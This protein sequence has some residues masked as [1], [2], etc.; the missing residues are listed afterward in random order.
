VIT[1]IEIY[2]IRRDGYE[3]IAIH[4]LPD[5][6]EKLDIEANVMHVKCMDGRTVDLELSNKI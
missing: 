6:F 3:I 1:E 4:S 5:I 2:E